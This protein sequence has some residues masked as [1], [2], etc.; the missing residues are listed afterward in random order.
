MVNPAEKAKQLS[1]RALEGK[2]VQL[3]IWPEHKRR[4]PNEIIRSALFSCRN[5]RTKREYFENAQIL[6]VGDGEISYTGQEL[7]T[8][9]EDIWMQVLH[10]A[11]KTPLGEKVIFR[12]YSFLRSIGW[13][14]TGHYRN[15]LES[16]L[17]RLQATTFKV[18]S[19][20]LGRCD[21]LS[22]IRRFHYEKDG[23]PLEQWEVWVEPEMKMLFGDIHYTELEWEQRK[24][25]TPIAKKM[26]GYYASHR[27]PYPITLD[28]MKA[29]CNSACNNKP[30]LRQMFNKALK[31]LI[32]IGFLADARIE[33]DKIYV[34]RKG[35]AH[36]G[37]DI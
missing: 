13:P 8:D 12:P 24:H 9:D 15:K 7:R 22:L 31:E 34:F 4:V 21:S 5:K 29:M 14:Q 3:P 25:L 37:D 19:K 18:S 23:Q 26:H 33:N 2:V 28:T 16:C 1:Q 27:Q 6:V 17:T 10:L 36:S 32:E 30:K 35:N 11:R 20:R